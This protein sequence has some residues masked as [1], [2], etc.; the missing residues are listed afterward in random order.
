[1]GGEPA[2][3]VRAGASQALVSKPAGAT[4]RVDFAARLPSP[5]TGG[6]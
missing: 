4:W 2:E 1:M 5:R 6:Q 3:G